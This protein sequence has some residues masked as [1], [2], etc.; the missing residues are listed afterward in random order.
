MSWHLST[1]GRLVQ[2]VHAPLLPNSCVH[3]SIQYIVKRLKEIIV[4]PEIAGPLP[5]N[6]TI[7]IENGGI[8]WRQR[9]TEIS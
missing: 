9:I 8:E 1:E 7:N 4:H 2:S 5:V 3:T 6:I